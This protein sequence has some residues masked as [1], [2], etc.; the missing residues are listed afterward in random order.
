MVAALGEGQKSQLAG[1]ESCEGRVLISRGMLRSVG[2]FTRESPLLPPYRPQ[3][4]REKPQSWRP[5]GTIRWGRL[6]CNFR[7]PAYLSGMLKPLYQPC[8]PTLK[9]G[10]DRA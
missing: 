1:N 5:S 8:I 3:A 9:Q 10:F 4:D 2:N 7:G 6:I